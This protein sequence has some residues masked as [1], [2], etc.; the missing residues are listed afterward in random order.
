MNQNSSFR[1]PGG[2]IPPLLRAVG[3]PPSQPQRR[4]V[5]DIP[6]RRAGSLRQVGDRLERVPGSL[7]LLGT[8]GTRVHPRSLV[9]S[10]LG[11][12]TR[13]TLADLVSQGGLAPGTSIADFA[14]T[15][16]SPCGCLGAGCSCQGSTDWAVGSPPMEDGVSAE[17]T[18]TGAP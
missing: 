1:V 18:P 15:G 10:A 2:S 7:G 9:L 13:R 16:A 11:S 14:L 3:G 17:S 4:E 5:D 6:I 12:P 8:A